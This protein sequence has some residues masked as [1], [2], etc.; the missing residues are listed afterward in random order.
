LRPVDTTPGKHQVTAQGRGDAMQIDVFASA[1]EVV[2]VRLVAEPSA[3][4]AAAVAPTAPVPT[5]AS[6]SAIVAA[7]EEP[8][9]KDA[10]D[11]Q[12]PWWTARRKAGV[13]TAGAGLVAISIGSYLAFIHGPDALDHG[14]TLAATNGE[15]GCAGTARNPTCDTIT[16]SYATNDRD[17]VLGPALIGLGVAALGAS[18][19]LIFTHFPGNKTGSHTAVVPLVSPY[20]AGVQ[21]TGDL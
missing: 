17:R 12:E 5:V 15:H 14:R 7:P 10:T 16:E 19:L 18:A 13:V 20:G 11:T 1:G 6:T 8:P 9:V 4:G 21:L 3:P 2:R